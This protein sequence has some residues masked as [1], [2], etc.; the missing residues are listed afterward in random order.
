M[1]SERDEAMEDDKD[2][3]TFTLLPLA[4]ERVFVRMKEARPSYGRSVD[5][6]D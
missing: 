2:V 5:A 4:A 6:F 1:D 3:S